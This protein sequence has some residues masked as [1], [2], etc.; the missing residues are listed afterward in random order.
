M[1]EPR[2]DPEEFE[3]GI[4]QI[5]AILPNLVNTPDFKFQHFVNEKLY[6]GNERVV[7]IND[8]VL[9]AANLATIE[10]VYRKLFNNVGG[11]TLTIVGNVDLETLKPMVEKYAGSLPKGKK[12]SK[13]NEDNLVQMAKG[14]SENVLNVEMQTPKKTVFQVWSAYMPVST[15]EMVTLEVANYVLDMI[16]TK[17][18]REKEGGTYGVGASLGASRKPYDRVTFMVQ[19]DTNPEQAEKLSGLTAQYLKE[20]AQNG[21]TAEELAMAMENLKKNVPESR[22]SN[23]Y[24]L[25]AVEDYLDHGIDYDAE[26]EAALNSVTA[27]DVKTLLQAVLAQENF[28][29]IML[30]PME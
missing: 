5:K 7:T 11:A 25:S 14:T 17:T 22:I 30:A 3:T 16:Y 6:G 4:Q 12:A 28:I 2:F 13:M 24:W 1:T 15:K 9:E 23:H 26:Y 21:P 27:E 20:F 18:I 10:K 29:Q 8:E 19:F